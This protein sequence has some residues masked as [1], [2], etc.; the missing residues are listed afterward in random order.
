MSWT[1][2]RPLELTSLRVVLSRWRRP[3]RGEDS[4]ARRV[5]SGTLARS[6]AEDI[7]FHLGRDRA[8]DCSWAKVGD[9]EIRAK[10]APR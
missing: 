9:F 5:G 3:P 6:L 2:I 7:V 8:I 10:S 4:G 1:P